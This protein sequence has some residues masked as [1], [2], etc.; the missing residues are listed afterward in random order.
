MT[1]VLVLCAVVFAQVVTFPFSHWDD[2]VHLT[3][4]PLVAHPL[5]EGLAALITTPALGY[6]EPV[7]VLMFWVERG[8]FGLVPWVFHLDNLL[9]HLISVVLLFVLARRLG[10]GERASALAALIFGVHPLVA[11]P[12]AWVTGRKELLAGALALGGL[13]VL[14]REGER[15]A[16]ARWAAAQLLFALAFFTKPTFGVA[17]V[18]AGALLVSRRGMP[19]RRLWPLLPLIAGFGAAALYGFGGH[20][21]IGAVV[22]RSWSEA[23]LDVAGAAALQLRHLVLPSDLG[24]AYYRVPG[25]PSIVA[26]VLGVAALSALALAAVRRR[27]SLVGPCLLFLVI[28]Y[29]PAGGFLPNR[30]WVADSY[31]YLTVSAFALTVASLVE[32]RWPAQLRRWGVPLAALLAL[33]LSLGAAVQARTFSANATLWQPVVERYPDRPEPLALLGFGQIADGDEA[34]AA[35]AF[36]TLADRWPSHGG[37]ESEEAWAFLRLGR[38]DRARERL[39]AGSAHG[40]RECAT[41]LRLL[42]EASVT[43]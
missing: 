27:G 14:L 37:V 15:I 7:M 43:P 8:L 41:K 2:S 33:T 11:E 25:D 18:V 38:V 6:P 39:Q 20:A 16:P 32:E 29:L 22:T 1:G 30:R 12:V 28:A 24:A 3:E 34:A 9:L 40:D 21:Q 35:I 23:A 19:L 31:M 13:V 42:D 26:M 17:P 36:S 5:S 4:N 10:L